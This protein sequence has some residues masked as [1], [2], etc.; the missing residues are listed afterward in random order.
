MLALGIKGG[1]RPRARW[2]RRFRG[3]RGRHGLGFDVGGRGC[4]GEGCEESVDVRSEGQAN[5][6]ELAAGLVDDVLFCPG[7]LLALCGGG[8]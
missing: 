8:F 7:C 5:V 3:R 2:G 4:R 6:V 1:T